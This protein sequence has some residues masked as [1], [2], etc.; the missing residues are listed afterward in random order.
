MF[1]THGR[2]V[3]LSDNVKTVYPPTNT[4]CGF[5]GGIKTKVAEKFVNLNG[6][7]LDCR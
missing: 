7:F 6:W 2:S 5:A 3:S 4:V 1:R